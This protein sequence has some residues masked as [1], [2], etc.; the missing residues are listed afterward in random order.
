[1]LTL[2]HKVGEFVKIVIPA[3][4][5]EQTILVGVSEIKG[6]TVRAGYVAPA[7]IRI[8]R[9]TK[10]DRLADHTSPFREDLRLIPTRNEPAL[11]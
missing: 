3:S 4:A 1:M 9:S 8:G 10:T 11:G 5:S 7:H 2:S 6:S